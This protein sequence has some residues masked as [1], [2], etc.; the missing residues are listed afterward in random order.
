MDVITANK[1]AD[2][3]VK[4]LSNCRNEEMWSH[5]DVIGQ[6]IR[7]GIKGMKFTFRD[8]KLPRTSPSRRLQGLTQW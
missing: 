6:K 1:T 2:A 4:T 8:A 5:A 7:I 3:V